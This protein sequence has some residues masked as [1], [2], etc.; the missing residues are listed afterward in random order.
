VGRADQG[1]QDAEPEGH[2]SVH[3][4]EATEIV[5]VP[6]CQFPETEAGFNWQLVTGNW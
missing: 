5:P 1:L 2:G 6:S 4:S 3:R